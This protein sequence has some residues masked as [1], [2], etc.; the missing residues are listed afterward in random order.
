M[1]SEAAHS[2]ALDIDQLLSA[3]VGVGASDLHL[4]VGGPPVYRI[5]GELAPAPEGIATISAEPILRL[6]ERIASPAQREELE[7]RGHL[8]LG[9]STPE[10]ARFRLNVYREMGRPAL[11][12]RYL[13][14]ALVS[15]EALGLPPQL[16]R[17]ARLRAGLVLV[18]G[19]TGSGKSTTLAALLDLINRTSA[20]HILTIQDP[21]EF[22][23]LP[24][25]SLIHHRELRSDVAS[26][27]D[28]VHAAL[29]E[30]PDVIMIGEM[31]DLDTMRAALT[32]AETGH[33]VFSTLHTG[34][35]IGC[36][37]RLVGAFPGGEQ[38]VARHRIG[39]ALKAVVAQRLLPRAK[40]AGRVAA[41]E[42][43]MVNP[44]VA[45]LIE[46]G[47][48]RQIFSAMETGAADGMRTMDQSLAELVVSGE[49]TRGEALGHCRDTQGFERL[50]AVHGKGR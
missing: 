12:A 1:S 6:L 36:I 40:E 19:A 41:A 25:R 10:G 35:A 8:D 13:D 27:A 37:E 45:N 4:T 31:R 47:K 22:V 33:L 39:M 11:A 29:R 17:L 30:D 50:L 46:Q 9:Y 44:A 26:F 21:V 15:L 23:H 28:A 20:R 7:R 42:V 14:P 2:G 49:A 32:A 3:A 16:E 34:E 43:L 5:H 48:T 38:D 18:T 24:K